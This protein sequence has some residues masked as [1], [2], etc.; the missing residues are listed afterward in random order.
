MFPVLLDIVKKD[1][2]SSVKD[3]IVDSLWSFTSDK[4][5]VEQVLKWLNAES[6]QNADGSQLYELKKN[7]KH[8]IVKVLHKSSLVTAEVKA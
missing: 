5:H 1:V 7:H 4:D 3:P 6:I 8:K 2:P